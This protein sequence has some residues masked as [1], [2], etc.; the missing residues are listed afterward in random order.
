[1]KQ[2]HG[3]HGTIRLGQVMSFDNIL[4]VGGGNALHVYVICGCLLFLGPAY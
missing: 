1:M 2:L 4:V 3:Q